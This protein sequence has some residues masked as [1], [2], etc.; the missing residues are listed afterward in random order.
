M[1]REIDSK[2]LFTL[3]V[4]LPTLLIGMI[5]YAGYKNMV[6]LEEYNELAKDYYKITKDRWK[7]YED[8]DKTDFNINGVYFHKQ[9]YCV[10]TQDRKPYDIDRTEHHE[11][12]HDLVAYKQ[13]HFC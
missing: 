1:K 12:C 6:L 10:W 4:I 9:Y 13:E 8:R 2:Y 5:G 7:V 11:E 3:W